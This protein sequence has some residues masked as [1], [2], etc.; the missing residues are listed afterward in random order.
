MPW[1]VKPI[2]CSL[3]RIA[4]SWLLWKWREG[5]V[6]K[7]VLQLGKEVF[8]RAGAVDAGLAAAQQVQVGAVD[9]E[10]VHE[11]LTVGNDSEQACYSE[12]L[13]CVGGFVCLT[14]AGAS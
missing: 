2:S 1:W 9:D 4:P 3:S 11:T 5:V 6:G 7:G 14:F 10:N 12:A 8:E 13:C